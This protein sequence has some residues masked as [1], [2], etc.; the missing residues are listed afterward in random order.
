MA[1]AANQALLELEKLLEVRLVPRTQLSFKLLVVDEPHNQ[2][3][4]MCCHS[5]RSLQRT[6]G[7]W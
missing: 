3:R 2:A 5:D 7:L 1:D 6:R 4:L